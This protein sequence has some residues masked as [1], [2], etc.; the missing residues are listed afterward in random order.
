MIALEPMEPERKIHIPT[1]GPPA[2]IQCPPEIYQRMGEENIFKM[3]SDFYRELGQSSIRS[4]FPDDLEDASKK[5]AAFFVGVLGGPPLYHQ[6]F[7]PPMMRKRHLRFTIDEGA[8]Q[9]WLACFE[10]TLKDADKKYQFPMEHFERFWNFLDKFSVWMV[11]T[12]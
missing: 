3:L 9:V 6:R 5:S 8:R 1:G 12:K 10:K 4:M 2:D 11:N 7:G